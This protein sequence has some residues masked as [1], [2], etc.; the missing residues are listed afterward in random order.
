[1]TRFTEEAGA[2]V[3]LTYW[4]NDARRRVEI[5]SDGAFDADLI[6]AA[7]QRQHREGIWSYAMLSDIRLVKGNP[8]AEELERVR[9]AEVERSGDGCHPGPLVIVVANRVLFGRAC[10]YAVLAGTNRPITVVRDRSE[11][12]DWL[13]EQGF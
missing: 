13:R 4:R 8:T 7:F 10:A 5:L 2:E 9:L 6:I 3:R 12:E 11:A 1:M